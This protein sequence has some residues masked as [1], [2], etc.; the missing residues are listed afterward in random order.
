[1]RALMMAR[2]QKTPGSPS[3]S[4]A[5]PVADPDGSAGEAEAIMRQE[6]AIY[7]ADMSAELAKMARTANLHLLSYFLDMAAAEARS[8]ADRLAQG[9]PLDSSAPRISNSIER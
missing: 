1:M 2:I 8:A 5:E 3:A 9:L 4:L 6:V 7:A